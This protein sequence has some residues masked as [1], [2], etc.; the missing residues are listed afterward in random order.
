MQTQ[1]S[2]YGCR[3]RPHIKTHKSVEIAKLQIAA[4]ACGIT[5]AKVSEAEIMAAGGIDD[6]FIAYP[7]IGTRKIER[8]IVLHQKIRRLILG[9]D[10]I[11]GAKAMDEQAQKWGVTLE[12]RMEID[13][14]SKRTGA[15]GDE[16]IQLG[17]YIKGLSHLKL[18]GIYSFKSLLYQGKTTF[19]VEQASQEE[20]ELMAQ[21]AKQLCD[22]GIPIED[23][24]AGSTPTGL[25]VA[26][27]GL[28]NEVRPG[29][30]VYY[31]YMTMLEGACQQEDIASYIYATVVSVPTPAY[32]IVDG[33]TKTFSADVTLQS[34]P[35]YFESYAYPLGREDLVLSRLNEE[36]GI[37]TSK[38][39]NVDLK[40]GDILPFLPTH[41]CTAVNQQNSVFMLEDGRLRQT[42][43]DA[44]GALT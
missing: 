4:G 23:V 20:G 5:C 7:L 9:V 40:V 16:M 11:A 27:T 44:R 3:L 39:G 31:D 18:T 19:D 29:T 28:V 13:T 30:Y 14:G 10:S 34:D 24:S 42:A 12:V 6:I 17:Q 38:K 25:A 37:L 32:A 43:V 35:F 2:S 8:A 22:M 26:K 15:V 33:G 1:V 21:A 41:I 36:H